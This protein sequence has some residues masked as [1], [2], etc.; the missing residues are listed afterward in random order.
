MK[1]SDIER[2]L[3]EVFRRAAVE[4]TPLAALLDAM[5]TLHDPVERRLD[6]LDRCFDP[7]RAPDAL[8]PMLAHW[9]DLDGLLDRAA[10]DTLPT[11]LP[12]GLGRLRELVANASELARR[13]GTSEGLRRFL[14][15]ATG[16][17]GFAIEDA[18]SPGPDQAT[19]FDIHVRA[20]AAAR[21]HRELVA[22]V[23][24]SEKPAHTTCT[25][26]F[27]TPSSANPTP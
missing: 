4:G 7:L 26:T 9:V 1:R 27:A 24:A 18:A 11:R 12:S 13:R 23:I 10:G 5:E 3:P 2:L 21:R 15:I 16:C 19:G 20:P 14:E 22:R 6:A 25:L 17:R 8:V